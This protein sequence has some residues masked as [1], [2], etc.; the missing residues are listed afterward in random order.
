MKKI[1]ETA[2]LLELAKE[3]ILELS[4]DLEALNEVQFEVEK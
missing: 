1:E 2:K 4:V 3:K